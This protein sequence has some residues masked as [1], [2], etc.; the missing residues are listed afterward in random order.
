MDKCA[1][2]DVA[3]RELQSEMFQKAVEEEKARLR[4]KMN[5]KSLW[6]RLLD[7]LPFTITWKKS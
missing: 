2:K 3:I 7:L 6:V 1:I 4:Q 5:R